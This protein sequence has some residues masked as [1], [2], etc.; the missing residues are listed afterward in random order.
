[1]KKNIHLIFISFIILIIFPIDWSYA[2]EI[3]SSVEEPSVTT[4]STK[5]NESSDSSES[6]VSDSSSSQESTEEEESIENEKITD[7]NDMK[8]SIDGN[9]SE[10]NSKNMLRADA[11]QDAD[12]FWLVDSAVTLTEYLKDSQKLKFRLTN[13]IDLGTA[14]Y[15][16]KDS[17]IIDGANH[18]ITYN[19]GAS[20]TRGFYANQ[21]NAVI[22]IRNTQ[23]GNS[24]GSGA[25]GYYGFLSGGS[26][27][28]MTFIFD[29]VDYYST[30]GQMIYNINGSVIMRGQNTIDQRGTSTYSQEWAEINYVEIQS[31]HTSIKH[32][33]NQTSAF[34]WSTSSS[35]ANPYA[36]KSQIVVRENAQLDIQTNSNMTYGTLAPSYIVEKNAVFNL[37]K[38]SLATGGTRN[39]FFASSQ[40]QPV[41]FDFQ[42]N[43]QVDFK[44]P[45]P[46]NLYS[47]KG[48][49]TIAENVDVSIDVASGAI[50]TTAASS[51]FAISMNKAK[52]VSFSGTSLGTIGLNGA[53]GINNLSFTSNYLQKIE[54]FSSKTNS[55]PTQEIFKKASDLSIQG[56]NFTNIAGTPDSFSA[57]EILALKNSQKLVF[58]EFMDVPDQLGLRATEETD[59]SVSLDGSSVNNGSPASEVKFFL[60]T[61]KGDTNDLRRAKHIVTLNNFD[62]QENT[63]LDSTYKVKVNDLNPNTTYWAQMVVINQAGE[64][65]F[66]DATSFTTKPQLKNITAD[67]TTTSAI[68]NGELASDTGKWT[69]FTNG[70]AAA[71]PDQIAYYGGNY[72]QVKVE[73]SKSKDFP[74]D[75]TKSQIATLTGNKNQKFS[76]KLKGLDG[77]VTYYV[78]V[79]VTGVSGEEVVLAMNPLTEFQTVTEIIKVEVPIEMAFQTQNKDLGTSKEG[80]VSSGEYQVV[81]KGNTPTKLSITNLTKENA[82]ANQLQLLDS[83]SGKSGQ[84]ELALQML[85]DNNQAAPLFLTSELSKNPLS[86]GV[87]NVNEEKSLSLQGKYFNP[88]KQAVFPTYKVTFKVEKNEE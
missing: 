31:G 18:I 59:T 64:S 21:A 8:N 16:L 57:Q 48:G 9:D 78:R 23:F 58:S 86:I 87:L 62:G 35:S 45:S 77:D 55:T 38:V 3:E 37:D 26:A 34:I 20:A 88:T 22:E 32:S 76:T 5:E 1:M 10:I 74:A 54:T 53:N 4:E 6:T 60:F 33:S 61:D 63:V 40:T 27:A 19:K 43:A 28:N 84:D 49:L 66:S 29:G 52:Q 39:Q 17:M 12:G 14:G 72:Q 13:N 81:N 46:I 69:D 24:D 79:R 36:G 85:V 73:Y 68:I 41:L 30:N 50:F 25:V 80:E 7:S 42:E 44:L 75:A 51:T 56:T 67:V 65:N 2:I 47:A 11:L 71:L 82:A 15:Q 83:L 70:E